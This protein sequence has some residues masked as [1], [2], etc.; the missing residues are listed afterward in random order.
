LIGHAHANMLKHTY[1]TI[2]ATWLN[3]TGNINGCYFYKLFLYVIQ[4][5]YGTSTIYNQS[6]I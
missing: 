1:V 3:T 5:T 2:T 4:S 6:H